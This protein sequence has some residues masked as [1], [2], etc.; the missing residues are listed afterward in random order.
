VLPAA[1]AGDRERLARFQREAEV[2][3]SLNH[4]DIAHIHGLEESDGTIALIMELVEGEDLAARLARGAIPLDE[5]LPIALQ[6]ADALEAAHEQGIIHRDLKPANIKLRQD[7]TVKVLDFGLAKALAPSGDSTPD[8]VNSPTITS[9]MTQMGMILGTAAYMSPEQA[10]GRAVDR[11]ADIWAFGCVLYEMLTGT[12]PFAGDTGTDVLA[13][14][15]RSDPDWDALPAGMPRAIRTTLRRCLAKDPKQRLRDIADARLEIME[16]ETAAAAIIAAPPRRSSSRWIAAI[17]LTAGAALAAGTAGG[18]AWR[19]SRD[20]PPVQWTGSRLGG[21]AI[22]MFPRVSPDGQLVAFQ[23]MVD[24]QSQVAVM[25][26]DTGNWSVLTRDRSKG[27]VDS[28]AWS[29]DGARVYYDRFTDSPGGIYSVP[30]LGGEERLLIENAARPEPLPD[31]SLLLVRLNNDRQPQIHRLWP[32]NGRLEPLPALLPRHFDQ[33][34]VVPIDEDR[35]V[36]FGR[37]LADPGA[38]SQVHVLAL[39]TGELKRLGPD[40]PSAD[41]VSITYARADR[42]L[43]VAIRDG[44]LF[45]V[46]HV[47]V[48]GRDAR[49]SML[50]FF[51]E[52]VLNASP[53]GSVFASLRERPAELLRFREG[54]RVAERLATSS[55]LFRGAVALPD[56]RYLITERLD[57]RTRVLIATPGQEPTPLVETNEETRDPMTAVAADRAALLIGTAAAPEIAIVAVDSGRI[58]KRLKAPGSVT[59]IAASPDGATLYV[60]HGGSVSAV[61]VDGGNPRVL[62]AGD[63]VTVDPASGDLILKLD[64]AERYRLVRLS[65]GGGSPSPIAITGDLRL[66]N[67]PLMPGAIRN[68]RLLLPVATANSWYWFTG[69]LDLRTGQL[70][71]V[72][73]DNPTDFHWITWAADGSILGSGMGVQSTL[74]K[75]TREVQR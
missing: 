66:V 63:S 17:I 40:L 18:M 71:R 5:A 62:G 8:L 14:V 25:K 72:E 23:A 36:F 49:P 60:T 27:L 61:P 9:P 3:A 37:P 33:N 64:E 58:M 46:L 75:F 30:A 24:G 44:S 42:S 20:V 48:D 16:P 35:T 56:G 19:T 34:F 53:D 22:A 73:V 2:L 21:P 26:P 31:G 50:R 51:T 11:R 4:P 57:A 12:Q 6:I 65:P 13:A 43:L 41:V 69:V 74:W 70:T 15:V 10:R 52:P 7:G 59:S 39:S 55:T 29:R 67:R 28:V 47:P 32:E 54:V 45:R 68:G 38:Q 1:V